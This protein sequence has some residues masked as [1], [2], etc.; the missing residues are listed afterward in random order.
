M[1][2]KSTLKKLKRLDKEAQEAK[3]DRHFD[4]DP[5]KAELEKTMFDVADVAKEEGVS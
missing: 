5:K 2:G 4:K 3:R 1:P